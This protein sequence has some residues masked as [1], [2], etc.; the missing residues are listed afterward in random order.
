[1]HMLFGA[2]AV[3]FVYDQ[4]LGCHKP[5]VVHGFQDWSN[6][7]GV[8]LSISASGALWLFAMHINPRLLWRIGSI[9]AAQ[10]MEICV[11]IIYFC[12]IELF[13]VHILAATL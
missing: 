3:V 7:A 9:V 13:H 4:M 5:F 2:M 10:S 11:L 1:M 8:I 12:F 6:P